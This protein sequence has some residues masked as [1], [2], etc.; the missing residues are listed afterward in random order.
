MTLT[1]QF[2]LISTLPGSFLA[3]AVY[4]SRSRMPRRHTQVS[5]IITLIMAVL[6]SSSV[7]RFYGG[8]TFPPAL[9]F[10]WG[11][12][13]SY[14]F[15]LVAAGFL[16]T[17]LNHL[18][19][20]ARHSR[21]AIIISLVL[22]FAALGLDASIWRYRFPEINLYSGVIQQFDL[23]A[24]V[25]VSSWL[26]PIVAA[27]ILTY[28]A[29]RDKPAS[30]YRNQVNYWL[31]VLV[32]FFTGGSLFSVRHPGQPAWQESGVLLIMLA[33]LTGTISISHSQLPDL[34]LA[35]R[36]IL[37]RLSGTLILFTLTWAVLRFLVQAVT[38]LPTDTNPNLILTLSAALF[39]GFFTLVYQQI[40]RITRRL[41]LPSL[42][43]RKTAQFDF[44]NIAGSLSDPA[45]LGQ[46]FLRAVQL[47]WA[48]DDAWILLVDDS[49]NGTLVLR[50]LASLDGDLSEVASFEQ[51]SPLIAYLR[52]QRMPLPQYDI[53]HL[54]LFAEMPAS[55]REV[56]T[57]WQ[58][59]LHVPLPAGERMVG[60][61]G[62]AEKYSGNSYDRRDFEK[63]VALA[64]Q[65]GPLLTQAQNLVTARRAN[66]HVFQQNSSLAQKNR[67]L[68]E[69]IALHSHF[70]KLISPD[71]R[72]PF[73]DLDEQMHRLRERLTDEES[74][75]LVDRLNQQL[76]AFTT[77]ID[78]LI[79]LGTQL[80]NQDS[81]Q[82]QPTRLDEVIRLS[83]EK[84]RFMAN[85]RQ[86]GIQFEPDAALP[87]I[88]GDPDK[89]QAVVKYLLHNAVAFSKI[90]GL[91]QLEF[92]I[93]D[94]HLR[95]RVID[96]GIG[97]DDQRLEA[98]A[99]EFANMNH[100]DIWSSSL[101]LPLIRY[102]IAAHGGWV[103]IQPR[104]ESS[105]TVYSVYLPPLFDT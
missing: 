86:V 90:G 73:I 78:H 77:P 8:I 30:L 7:L 18:S 31:L 60:L 88:S 21:A 49:S 68:T 67:Q 61:L 65:I 92:G 56:V 96:N 80:A 64:S 22:W 102:I 46:L 4:L 41:F 3:M 66:E 24:A 103:D 27:T 76:R 39:A 13:G 55:E 19:L 14:A 51:S 48:V 94:D 83:I 15:S 45:E 33:A 89:L 23:W 25:W 52:H 10:T 29:N 6:W 82:M 11:V 50:C 5:W 71:L 57:G 12:I 42:A 54:A 75:Q 38:N 70:L 58:K 20:S 53:D 62:L 81:P 59:A 2:L 34:Q 93:V 28:Q 17:T 36:R 97:V 105:G 9:V 101:G 1:Q 44:T 37:S 35:L 74:R 84:V 91:V 87:L 99:G 72:R 104:H 43:R 47:E 79:A 63:L 69:L 95:L 16:V 26:I 100:G 85:A 40:N 98:A 32:I